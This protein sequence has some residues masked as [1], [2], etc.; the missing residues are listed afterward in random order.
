MRILT[1]FVAQMDRI[2]EMLASF[3][4]IT[5]CTRKMF[6]SSTSDSAHVLKRQ[7]GNLNVTA[8]PGAAIELKCDDYP[9]IPDCPSRYIPLCG[10]NGKDYLNPCY[11]CR[12]NKRT[13]EKV[14][15]LHE[16]FCTCHDMKLS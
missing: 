16:G 10:T 14:A 9:K 12:H 13:G 1:L 7:A 15:I 8:G 3:V 4:N 2:M 6:A 5:G 11:L